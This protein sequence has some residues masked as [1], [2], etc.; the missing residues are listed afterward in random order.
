MNKANIINDSCHI[1]D[2][3]IPLHYWG[4]FFLLKNKKYAKYYIYIDNLQVKLKCPNSYNIMLL[5]NNE[6]LI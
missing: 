1:L 5:F 4:S 3:D 6:H 2:L